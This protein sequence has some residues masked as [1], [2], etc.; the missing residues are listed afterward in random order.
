MCVKMF[1]KYVWFYILKV[2]W[3]EQQVIKKRVKR[4][5]YFPHNYEFNDPKWSRMWYL[6]G[7]VIINMGEGRGEIEMWYL[8]GIAYYFDMDPNINIVLMFFCIVQNVLPGL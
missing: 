3:L 8:V 5:I 4:D 7:I 1:K 2:H 6:V